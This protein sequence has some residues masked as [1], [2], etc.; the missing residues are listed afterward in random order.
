MRIVSLVPSFTESLTQ[1]ELDPVAC[2]RFC[3][4]KDLPTIG[5]TKNPDIDLI[6][7]LSPDLVLIDEQENRKEDYDSLASKGIPLFASDVRSLEDLND[8]F[9]QLSA[10][11]GTHWV[12]VQLPVQLPVTEFS[13]TAFVPIWRRP[14]I[15]LGPRTFGASVLNRIGAK[16]LPYDRGPYPKLE[17]SEILPLH[18][19]LVIAPSEPYPFSKRHLGE[20]SQIA[21]TAFVD[22]RD[23]FWWGT[24]TRDA[25]KRL[26]AQITLL[27]SN[28]SV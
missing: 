27:S 5:G 1:W 21:P 15:A 10:L 24:R 19:D 3:P 12:P 16:V 17:L 9:T 20:L 6:V 25:V 7:K 26:A 23:L 28:N 4:R 13:L 14:W 18:P 2:T 22:G 11:L 8:T